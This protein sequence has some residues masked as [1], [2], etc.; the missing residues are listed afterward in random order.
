VAVGCVVVGAAP[1]RAEGETI[2]GELVQAV[3]E[4]AH[5]AE[6]ADRGDEGPLSWVE[7]TDGD[8]VRVPTE[9]LAAVPDAEPGATVQLVL[10]GEVTDAATERNGLE[11]AREVLDG[12]V[13]A[14]AEEPAP[15]APADPALTDEVTVV[16]VRPGGA[17]ADS[18]TAQ[19]VVDA[20]N[21]PVADFWAE[22][23]GGAIRLGATAA[24][25]GWLTTTATCDQPGLLWDEVATAVHWADGPGRH[26]LLYLPQT[27]T[28]CEYGLAEVGWSLTSGGRLYVRDVLAT[29]IAHE[30]GHNFGLGHSSGLQCDRT[31]D[32]G[33]CRT[34]PYRDYYDV[35]GVSWERTGTLTAAQADRLGLL[36]ADRQAA[37]SAAGRGALVRLSPA[38]SAG[39]TRAVRLTDAEG[40][41]YW[42]ELRTATGRDAWLGSA[43][44]NR[45]RLQPGVL[46]HRSSAHPD[47]S[48]LLD[49]TPS[50]T[51]RWVQDWAPAL[52]L[53]RAVALSGG[54]LTVT[55]VAQSG[56]EATVRVA[57]RADPA[58]PTAPRRP[59]G[60]LDAVRISGGRVSV[61]GWA[62][63]PNT[64]DVPATV[65]LYVD[66]RGVALSA[67]ATRADVG[68]VYPVAGGRHG[69]AF[70]ATVR[71]GPHRVCAYAIDTAA[72]GIAGAGNT[73]LGCRTVTYVPRLPIG[74]LDG[75]IAAG[76]RLSA[77][78]WTIDPDAPTASAR[79]H[80][81]VDG[82]AVALTAARNRADI[83][84]VF[85]AAGGAHGFGF[86]TTV[87]PGRHRVCAYAIDTAAG[88]S[89]FLGCRTT[90]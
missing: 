70:S 5:H 75:A 21:G 50:P 62:V 22:Q 32:T 46:V 41:T 14:P 61:G 9:D 44:Q 87:G 38:A 86:S 12:E 77:G 36:P 79:V 47:T 82:R 15:P 56:T 74:R 24:G 85:P 84:R 3:P 30:L 65:H 8:V 11:P 78:G 16:L 63:D 48:L 20:V 51:A 45:F 43:A 54:D 53:G 26:L 52:P 68:R 4:Y 90:G 83:A 69:Y 6:A 19:Q 59:F 60:A 33:R 81:Y 76:G 42:L 17:P 55:V 64:P 89:T 23:S 40:S 28:Q 27:A 37:V 7:T 72:V 29:L 18:R 66:G 34:Q 2:V 13:L 49:G 1:A 80:L 25:P 58:V 73:L 39:G 10:G 57:T 88:G 35:M 31:V 71:P 67:G